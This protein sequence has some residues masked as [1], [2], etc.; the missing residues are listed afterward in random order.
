MKTL[1][2]G[3][4]KMNGTLEECGSLSVAVLDSVE[5]HGSFL[6]KV[7]YLICPP[8]LS[9]QCVRGSLNER[10]GLVKLGAQNCSAHDSGAYTGDVSAQMIKNVGCEYVI[11]GHS[12]RREVFGEVDDVI[13]EKIRKATAQGLSVI[14]C[15]G[16]TEAQREQGQEYKIVG[17]QLG[18]VLSALSSEIRA[19]NFVVA[20]EPVWAIGTG[21][22]ATVDDVEA[23]HG[24]I[25]GQLKE[26]LADSEQIRILY[27][28]S[29]KPANAKEILSVPN[30]DGALI[31]GASL[32]AKDF[33]E[34]AASVS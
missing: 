3:N 5:K 21:K 19:D 27:G 30:V 29:V 16:E 17:A 22:V 13:V 20:Y 1:I 33:V 34:I 9:L 14:L 10:S 26:S 28:G 32:N 8:F 15:V 12:E 25:R 2:A 23:M 6:D 24:F 18:A 4:W 31:G 7:E 11:I